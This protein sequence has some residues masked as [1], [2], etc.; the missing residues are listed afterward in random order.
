MKDKKPLLD[1]STDRTGGIVNI[2]DS[3]K[4]LPYDLI[5]V[6]FL[7]ILQ[8]DRL[9]A[10][11]GA[12]TSASLKTAKDEK[13][14][15]EALLEILCIIIPSASKGLL[16]KLPLVEKINTVNAYNEESGLVKKNVT[17]LTQGPK[18]KKKNRR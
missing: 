6:H 2:E 1:L 12:L 13:K 8:R 18:A 5:K 16:S 3:G 17:Q 14:Y 4:T 10:L 7:N 15:D 9:V 11:S